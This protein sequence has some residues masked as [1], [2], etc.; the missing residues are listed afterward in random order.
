MPVT[1]VSDGLDYVIRRVLRNHGLGDLPVY[2]N[3][4]E[5]AGEDGYALSF[6]HARAD[7]PTAS[8]TCKCALLRRLRRPGSE[9]VLVGDGASDV[10]A[11]REAADSVF[12]KAGLLDHCR[13]HGLPHRAYRDFDDV[14]RA[15]FNHQRDRCDA[16]PRPTGLC[17]EGY[18]PHG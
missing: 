5:T 3:R 11:A 6:P 8:G 17:S 4:L 13:E 1:I 15:L 7:C 2:A 16:Q 14:T 12:A 10:C 9:A 18:P